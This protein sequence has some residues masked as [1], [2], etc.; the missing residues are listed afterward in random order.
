MKTFKNKK[1]H[2]SNVACNPDFKLLVALSVPRSAV[3]AY[4][5]PAGASRSRHQGEES[6]KQHY[7]HGAMGNRLFG[8]SLYRVF[9]DSS[10]KW[11]TPR[12]SLLKWKES[13]GATG[14]SSFQGSL[15]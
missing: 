5:Q 4:F 14:K 13:L 12:L 2:K 6:K 15:L 9:W 3:L 11:C 10:K 1:K 7:F 8:H